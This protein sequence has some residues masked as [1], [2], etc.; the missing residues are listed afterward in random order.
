MRNYV[1]W[2][3]R[4]RLVYGMLASLYY[5]TLV[6]MY[7]PGERCI[8]NSCN[9][10]YRN[11]VYVGDCLLIHGEVV[12]KREGTHRIKIKGEMRNQENIIV[13]SAEIMVGFTYVE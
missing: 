10:I 9:V 11:P 2:G 4:D 12:D 5:S 1:R 3:Y 8:L 6:G 7:L 13:N